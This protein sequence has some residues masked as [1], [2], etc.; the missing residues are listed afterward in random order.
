MPTKKQT[1]DNTLK[2]LSV[3]LQA[4]AKELLNRVDALRIMADQIDR[5]ESPSSREVLDLLFDHDHRRFIDLTLHQ[6]VVF[7]DARTDNIR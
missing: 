6:V 1:A 4:H 2:H 3:S 7:N 5:G